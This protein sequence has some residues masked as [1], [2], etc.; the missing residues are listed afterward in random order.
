MDG[1]SITIDRDLTAIVGKSTVGIFLTSTFDLRFSF[2]VKGSIMSFPNILDF[3]QLYR[4]VNRFPPSQPEGSASMKILS[5]SPRIDFW[6]RSVYNYERIPE[7]DDPPSPSNPGSSSSYHYHDPNHPIRRQIVVLIIASIMTIIGFICLGLYAYFGSAFT[8]DNA[9]QETVVP[10]LFSVVYA[11]NKTLVYAIKNP[12]YNHLQKAE[13]LPVENLQQKDGK[14]PTLSLD[15]TIISPGDPLVV[16]WTTGD[17]SLTSTSANVYPLHDMDIIAFFC[18]EYE[19]SES[20][21]FLEAATL[22]QIRATSEFHRGED[23]DHFYSDD[24]SSDAWF[25]PSFPHL[26]QNNCH[27]RLYSDVTPTM[28]AVNATDEIPRQYQE[29]AISETLTIVQ[30]DEM[31]SA[32]HMALGD[33]PTRM[34]LHFTTGYVNDT[35]PVAR[36]E[37]SDGMSSPP[38]IVEGTTDT[39]TA[40]DLC[41]AP[42][43]ITKAGLFYPPG[44]LHVIE[45][46]D[47]IPGKEYHYQVGLQMRNGHVL[48][49]SDLYTFRSAP[50]VG[51]SQSFSYIVYGDQG[52]PYHGWQGGKKWMESMMRR[53]GDDKRRRLSSVHHFGDISYARGAS[54][55]WD[56]WFDMIQPMSTH[57]PLMIAVGNHEYDHTDGGG[58]GK[59]PSGVLTPHGYMP[60]WGNFGEDSGGECAVP[61]AKRFRMPSSSSSNVSNST[62]N[63]GVFWYSYDYASVHTVVISSEHDLSMSSPQYTFLE[64][65]LANVDRTKTPWVILESHRPLYEGE[66]SGTFWKQNL[67]SQA[68][69]EELEDLLS[70]YQVDVVFAGH[71]HEYQR[72]CDGLYKAHCGRGGPIH[73]TVGSA[74]AKLDAGFDLMNEWTEHFIKGEF[75]YGRVTVHNNTDLHFEF[76]LHGTDDEVHAGVVLD[77]V[78][79]HR[80]R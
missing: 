48:H 25:I 64:H 19:S 30:A 36:I 78:W 32:I 15:Q 7:K 4:Q 70:A 10:T 79:I 23:N 13:I 73:I 43:N 3:H 45:L 2:V 67:V 29:L 49:W 39:Y 56:A 68:I 51:D 6:N 53:E 65:D 71:Y 52:C 75:G 66:A 28:N 40:E 60:T 55:V 18:E 5:S 80:E 58:E 50:R 77:D 17:Y 33:D 21:S 46:T 12:I 62:S 63:N 8:V 41:Q 16:T 20:F 35:I 31:P 47:L 42:A 74:G 44:L 54:H 9:H 1:R 11:E 69:R 26:R 59:D 14:L 76:V 34:I 72:T 27:F 38:R 61:M 37:S 22:A 57:L 24:S